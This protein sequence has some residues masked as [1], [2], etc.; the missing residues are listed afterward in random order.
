[1]GLNKVEFEDGKQVTVKE[2]FDPD[3]DMGFYTAVG[4][5]NLMFSRN[6]EFP[7]FSTMIV[8]VSKGAQKLW[9][10]GLKRNTDGRTNLCYYP[11]NGFSKSEK[12]VFYRLLK[13]LINIG[14]IKRARTINE[15]GPIPKDTLMVNPFV[16][17][18]S[19]KAKLIQRHWNVL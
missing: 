12:T 19:K 17:I 1:M 16:I 14:L 8:S 2:G 10:T 18:P 13:E 3:D 5:L 11:T 9:D 15:V 4:R 7:D 6:P